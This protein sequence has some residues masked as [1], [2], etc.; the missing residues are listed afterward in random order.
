MRRVHRA[1]R[2]SCGACIVRRMHLAASASRG[3]AARAACGACIV[4]RVHRAASAGGGNRGGH[5]GRSID[6]NGSGVG[7]GVGVCVR[8]GGGGGGG[9]GGYAVN[10]E[11][12]T[13]RAAA[14]DG[15]KQV[16]TIGG[17]VLLRESA[18]S[19]PTVWDNLQKEIKRWVNT[20]GFLLEGFDSTEHLRGGSIQPA[21]NGQK[22]VNKMRI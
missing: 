21:N 20:T 15:G 19:M 9:G 18:A 16:A 22:D 1:A 8:V 12:M 10:D 6:A 17:N 3:C 14:A 13:A 11:L 2:A 5:G 7:V 4:R